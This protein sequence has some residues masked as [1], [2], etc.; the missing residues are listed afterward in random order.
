MYKNAVKVKN[1]KIEEIP[2]DG[3]KKVVLPNKIQGEN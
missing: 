3:L 2:K 1:I